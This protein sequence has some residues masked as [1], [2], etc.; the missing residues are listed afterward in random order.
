MPP[1]CPVDR[2]VPRYTRAASQ[3]AL[4]ATGLPGGSLRSSLQPRPHRSRLECHRL[5]RWIVTFLATARQPPQS[6]NATGLPGG[7]LRSSLGS[8]PVPSEKRESPPGKPVASRG[9]GGPACSRE[10]NDPH[11]K[12][13]AFL[14]TLKRIATRGHDRSGGAFR[15][16]A[17]GSGLEGGRAEG[18]QEGVELG[19]VDVWVGF[20]EFVSHL[21]QQRF[22]V[23]AGGGGGGQRGEDCLKELFERRLGS[24]R[25]SVGGPARGPG[26]GLRGRWRRGW[27]A[28]GRTTR[29]TARLRPAPR[30]PPSPRTRS[31]PRPPTPRRDS[32]GPCRTAR[33]RGPAMSWQGVH[34]AFGAE[35]MPRRGGVPGR[36]AYPS[37]KRQRR[38]RESRRKRQAR[39]TH[40][41]PARQAWMRRPEW[42]TVVRTPASGGDNS[43]D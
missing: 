15:F 3:S 20:A 38:T 6:P 4:N 25:R 41:S 42:A 5:A 14:A 23:L 18:G 12:R 7:S 30:S 1:A 10:R 36:F 37:L 22:E 17:I 16:A 19:F 33:G 21:G 28:G 11:G 32:T 35:Y 9:A 24:R 26:G 40:P 8:R 43:P 39:R 34:P 2:Y 31:R 29:G 27:R 13:G